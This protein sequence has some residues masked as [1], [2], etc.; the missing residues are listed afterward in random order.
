MKIDGGNRKIETSISH[1]PRINVHTEESLMAHI[2]SK[3][4]VDKAAFRKQNE[5]I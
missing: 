4:V 3:P 5:N 2:A 1:L